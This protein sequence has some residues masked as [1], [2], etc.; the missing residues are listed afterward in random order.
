MICQVAGLAIGV[1]LGAAAVWLAKSDHSQVPVPLPSVSNSPAEFLQQAS[2]ESTEANQ[3]TDGT[4]RAAL[5]RE[6]A[7]ERQRLQP[8]SA[9]AVWGTLQ[10]TLRPSS[11]DSNWP[12]Q[13]K[14]E[15]AISS[16]IS[17]QDNLDT[18]LRSSSSIRDFEEVWQVR[19]EV[20]EAIGQ[21]RLKLIGH[22]RKQMS[23]LPEAS[24]SIDIQHAQAALGDFARFAT[25]NQRAMMLLVA[26]L[27]EPGHD[28]DLQ[29]FLELENHSRDIVQH[30]VANTKVQ[31]DAYRRQLVGDKSSPIEP[32]EQGKLEKPTVGKCELWLLQL[33]ELG[34]VLTQADLESWQQA[35]ELIRS[36]ASKGAP[37]A[38]PRQSAP[39]KTPSQQSDDSLGSSLAELRNQLRQ[40]QVLAYNHWALRE[41]E[42]AETVAGWDGR[43]A[44]IDAGLLEPAVSAIY[45]SVYGRRIEEIKDPEQRSRTVQRLLSSERVHLTAF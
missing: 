25:A 40:L 41:L 24:K 26:T 8:T 17:Y 11:D 34:N 14:L 3:T 31:V 1:S 18:I 42:A 45:A 22:V 20:E 29:E 30:S 33:A 37:P 13:D 36:D 32:V 5:L 43:L 6:V 16:M 35:R 23:A 39:E 15:T 38:G 9:R 44:R 2:T 27:P 12:Q 28:V 19:H 4:R 10:D 7:F 21:L